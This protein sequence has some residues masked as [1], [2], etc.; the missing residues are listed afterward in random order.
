MELC[1]LRHFTGVVYWKGYRE[2]SQRPRVAQPSCFLHLVLL[3]LVMLHL[4]MLHLA[5]P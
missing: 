2:A 4:V 5:L 1:H 3:H